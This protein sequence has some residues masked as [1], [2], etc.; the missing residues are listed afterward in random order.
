LPIGWRCLEIATEIAIEYAREYSFI[1]GH[2]NFN[3][4]L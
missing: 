4:S 3:S 2:V 1:G